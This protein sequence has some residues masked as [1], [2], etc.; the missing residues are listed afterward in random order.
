MSSKE[1]LFS[2]SEKAAITDLVKQADVHKNAAVFGQLLAN[3]A[4]HFNRNP[5]V[6]VEGILR[7]LNSQTF[8]VARDIA[9]LSHSFEAFFPNQTGNQDYYIWI[10][11]NG[12]AEQAALLEQIGSTSEK[13]LER[14]KKSGFL[15]PKAGSNLSRASKADLN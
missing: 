15:S 6:L 7:S 14:L 2:E 12:Q 11:V 5:F 1:T 4:R 8:L 13:N 3:I 9:E 10:C